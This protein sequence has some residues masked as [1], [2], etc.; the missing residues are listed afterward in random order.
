[1]ATAADTRPQ[2]QA[3]ALPI[4]ALGHGSAGSAN[5]MRHVQLP[6]R[7]SHHSFE[8]ATITYNRTNQH[9]HLCWW[10]SHMG[11]ASHS[12]PRSTQVKMPLL[13]R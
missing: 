3:A 10:N 5:Q 13:S 1:M 11:D 6:Y 2:L 4:G 7:R 8:A 12:A 9:L